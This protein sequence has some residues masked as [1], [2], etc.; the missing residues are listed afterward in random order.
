MSFLKRIM[1]LNCF[2]LLKNPVSIYDLR[3]ARKLQSQNPCCKKNNKITRRKS[4]IK[5]TH[6]KNYNS[7]LWA[8]RGGVAL[9]TGEKRI[10]ERGNG[11]KEVFSSC[12]EARE[13]P[14]EL[15][16]D[17]YENTTD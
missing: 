14:L 8:E 13:N 16:D 6:K 1:L 2:Q 5:S 12:L 7:K 4:S 9:Q 11:E 15:E 10:E 3:I 17:A